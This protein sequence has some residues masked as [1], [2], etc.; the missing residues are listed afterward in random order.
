MIELNI[1]VWIQLANFLITLV[2]LNY[3]LIRPILSI[4]RERKE[5]VDGLV[6]DIDSFADRSRELLADYEAQLAQARAAANVRRK[7]VK[8]EAETEERALLA[9]AAKEAQARIRS[10][11]EAVREEAETARRALQGEMKS[12]VTA[13]VTKLVG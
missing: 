8:A 2:V 6:G 1:T 5:K 9:E 3:L 7:E 4:I 11:Q 13:A 10:S 12:F